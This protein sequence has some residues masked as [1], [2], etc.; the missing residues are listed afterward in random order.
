[1]VFG[2]PAKDLFR[3]LR[4]QLGSQRAANAAYARGGAS[5]KRF[6]GVRAP[7]DSPADWLAVTTCLIPILMA[8]AAYFLDKPDFGVA[9]QQLDTLVKSVSRLEQV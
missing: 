3:L 1:M 8:W 9:V 4:P 5:D 7:S 2:G 6:L